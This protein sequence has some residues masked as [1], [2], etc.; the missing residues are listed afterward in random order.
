MVE[1]MCR[2]R[3]LSQLREVS[4]NLDAMAKIMREVESHEIE[5]FG[6]CDNTDPHFGGADTTLCA[7][8][9]HKIRSAQLLVDEI[10]HD[11]DRV[12]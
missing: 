1:K 5:A 2:E 12:F 3:A 10:F 4:S 9:T 11:L 8:A 6:E 7:I